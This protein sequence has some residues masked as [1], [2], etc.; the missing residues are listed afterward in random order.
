MKKLIPGLFILTVVLVMGSVGAM[1]DTFSF[2]FAGGAQSGSGVITADPTSTPGEFAITGITGVTDGFAITLLEAPSSSSGFNDNL[3]FY[4]VALGYLDF[5]GVSYILSNGTDVNLF[6][7]SGAY[8][9]AHGSLE[10]LTQFSVTAIPTTTPEPESLLLLGTGM[11]G[12]V[13][14]VRRRFAA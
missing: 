3:L 4:P 2:S 5:G 1:A 13:G 12:V 7:A 11:L 14:M 8:L 6:Y 10:V 9:I